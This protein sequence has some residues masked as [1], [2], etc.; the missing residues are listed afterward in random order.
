VKTTPAENLCK[1]VSGRGHTLPGRASN[2][3]REGS[4]HE[5]LSICKLFG[6]RRRKD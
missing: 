4:V 5:I 2:G 1:N 3:D 6:V